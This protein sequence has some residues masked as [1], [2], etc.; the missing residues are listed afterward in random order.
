ME[1]KK[2]LNG[3]P[4]SS[5]L[6]PQSSSSVSHTAKALAR[7]LAAGPHA[8][9]MKYD[10]TADEKP[11]EG[12]LVLEAV[13]RDARMPWEADGRRWHTSERVT[14]TGAKPRWEG[15]IVDWIVDR[16]HELGE[17]S[18]T[19]W[20][21]RTIVEIAA[22]RK[23]QGWFLH[24][25][26]GM[27]WLIRLV[28]RVARNTFREEDLIPNLGIRPLDETPG[29]EVYSSKERV[30]VANRKGPWQEV[31]ILAHRLNEIDTP[32]FRELLK[33]AVTS[34]QQTIAR[35]NTKP[36][37]VMPWKVNGQRWHL[38][39]KGFPVGRKMLWD[40][41]LLPRLIETVQ[42]VEPAL[43]IQ[44]DTRSAI[45]LR[46]PGIS[47]ALAQWRTK[48]SYGLDCRFQGKK[49]QF[50]LSRIETFGNSP[51][52]CGERADSD[53]L[54]LVFQNNEHVHAAKLKELLTEHLRGFREMHGSVKVTS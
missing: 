26:T 28:F 51:S 8:E 37:D 38:S 32:A 33:Q 52:V 19:D 9:R 50:N 42:E 54:R 11:R 23:S 13:G 40:H 1:K 47:R 12:D 15:T 24:L 36:E 21:Q 22:A 20:S 41:S 46:L 4:R 3:D 49:G 48:E 34:F 39:E 7:V 17:F 18:E 45:S 6:D 44:W 29:L 35:M 10:P 5:I 43:E 2:T 27:E 53:V 31:A 14:T 16:V 30:H 25:H